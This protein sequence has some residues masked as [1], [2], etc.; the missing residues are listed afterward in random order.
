MAHTDG[1]RDAASEC[2]APETVALASAEGAEAASWV[3]G[4]VG[5]ALVLHACVEEPTHA[6]P[7]LEGGGLVQLRDCAPEPHETEHAVQADQ[8]PFTET[9]A[10]TNNISAQEYTH[11]YLMYVSRGCSATRR[12]RSPHA[13]PCT[14][15][16]HQVKQSTCRRSEPPKNPPPSCW[17][18]PVE[19]ASTL[20]RILAY[21]E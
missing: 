13:C 18:Q 16:T 17:S 3:P 10:P 14:R 11:D 6:L 2:L 15:C 19:S 4:T 1:P 5:H 12:S 21:P 7:P 9:G 8:T 20:P